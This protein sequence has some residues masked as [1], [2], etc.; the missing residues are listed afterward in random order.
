MKISNFKVRT[1]LIAGFSILLVFSVFIAL[2]AVRELGHLNETV[3]QLTTEDWDTIQGATNLRSKIRTVSAKSTEMLLEDAGN[4]PKVLAELEDA[5]EQ[6]GK[7][8]E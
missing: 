6:I 1:R 8:F 7:E 5:R 3:N 2:F 4:R